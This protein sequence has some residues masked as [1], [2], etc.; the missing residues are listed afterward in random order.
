[1]MRLIIGVAAALWIGGAA[2]QTI[3]PA[4]GS[5]GLLT[6]TTQSG[7]TYTLSATDCGTEINF[8][9]NSAVTVTIPATLPIGCSVA[10]L[11]VGTAKVS[12]NGSAVTPATLQT[13]GGSATGTA[14]QWAMIGVTIEANVGG[15]AAVAVLQG[16]VS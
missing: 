8:T 12:V 9:S 6:V 14:G 5:F 1:M 2:A 16:N 3:G 13:Y 11:Q 7:T 15:S 10:A 4:P